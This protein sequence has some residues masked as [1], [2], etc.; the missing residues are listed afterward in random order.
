MKCERCFSTDGKNAE[1]RVRSDVIDLKVCPRCASEA[2]A[3]AL[4]VTHH[5]TPWVAGS[6]PKKHDGLQSIIGEFVLI[7][8]KED[9]A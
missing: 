6:R 7:G 1:F 2:R 9:S 3:L 4:T 8:E 5:Q